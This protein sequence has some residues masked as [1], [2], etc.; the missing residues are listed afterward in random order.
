[1]VKSQVSLKVQNGNGARFCKRHV[2]DNLSLK[3]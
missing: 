1:M 3:G 2:V